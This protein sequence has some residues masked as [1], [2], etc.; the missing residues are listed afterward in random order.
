MSSLD[1]ALRHL[2]REEVRAALEDAEPA[3]RNHGSDSDSWRSRVHTVHEDTRL[4]LAEC[5]EALD[6]SER[7]VRR[8]I[9]GEGDYPALPASKGPAG[10]TVAAGELLRWL[11]DVEGG[12]RFRRG[13]A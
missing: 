11:E 1:A 2:V 6:V 9:A 8:Y 3:N 13:A 4:T 10:T 12:N 5:A 7:S